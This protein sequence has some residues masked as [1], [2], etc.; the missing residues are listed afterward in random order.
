MGLTTAALAC[1]VVLVVILTALLWP[2][3]L[4]ALAVVGV[5]AVGLALCCTPEERGITGGRRRGL[6]ARGKPPVDAANTSGLFAQV[7]GLKGS[8]IGA[9]VVRRARRF[10]DAVGRG[11]GREG[12][13]I[14]L[15]GPAGDAATLERMRAVWLAR[16]GAP[17]PPNKCQERGR[18]RVK[19]IPDY[20]EFAAVR[21]AARAD[22]AFKYLDVGS[23]EGCITAALAEELGLPKAR[24]V[25]CDVTPQPPSDVFEFVLADGRGLPFA[26]GEFDL[27]S[28]FMSAHHFTDADRMFAEA[29][30]VAK[31]GARLLAREHG[32]AD[33]AARLY[34]DVV[35]AFYETVFRPETT[36]A[37]FAA[38]YATARPYAHYR[39]ADEWARLAERAGFAVAEKG[40]PRGDSFDTIYL[41]FRKPWGRAAV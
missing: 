40:E 21:A 14:M 37:E 3:A 41:L 8:E 30:R 29:F 31:P 36:P 18:V 15:A 20:A 4:A 13:G 17:S 33:E 9:E 5:A 7:R 32:R 28:M 38:R 2:R 23:A 19:D 35:H 25:A 12:V 39:T 26:D 11:F 27:I 24:A 6:R 22:P 10:F 16:G 1:L 34:Y